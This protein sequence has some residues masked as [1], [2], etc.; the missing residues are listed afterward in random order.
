[1]ITILGAGLA[2]LSCSYYLGHERCTLFE[3]NPYAGGH[4]HS[5]RRDGCVWD[6]GPH[7]SFTRNAHVRALFEESVQGDVREIPVRVGNYYHGHWIPHPAQSNLFAVPEPLRTHCLEDFLQTRRQVEAATPPADYQQWLEQAFGP[8]FADALPRRYT[9]K[10]WTVPPEQLATDW[11]GGRV[12]YPDVETVRRGYHE[13]EARSSHYIRTARYPGHGGYRAFAAALMENA[14]VH[15]GREVTA[16]DLRA[17]AV[18]LRDGTRHRFER[19][20][21]TLPL[22]EFIRMTMDTPASVRRAAET[23]QCSSLLLVNVTADDVASHPFHWFYVYDED[24][25]AT[26]VHHVDRLSPNNA[27]SGKTGIQVEVYASRARPFTRSFEAIAETVVRELINMGV[28]ERC[29]SVHTEYIPYANVI[30]DHERREAQNTILAWLAE[31]GLER[32]PDDLEPMTDWASAPARSP[33]PITLA[34]RF[35][36]WKYFWTD[37]CVLRGRQL[38]GLPT[39]ANDA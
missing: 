5:H 25:L 2:G 32:E 6:E 33:G 18:H 3:R 23:L 14:P 30:F 35:A 34:G 28:I 7:I 19:L 31:F 24:K 26:R 29:D 38:A 20:I 13:P 12:F 39:H 10:Y 21:N 22:P 36:Q 15:L 8:T 9:E 16:I 1:M 11:I 37:D 17:R 27:P 4:I